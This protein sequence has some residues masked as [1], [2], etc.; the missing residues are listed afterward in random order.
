MTWKVW[1]SS[2]VGGLLNE[3]NVTMHAQLDA[4]DSAIKKGV[5]ATFKLY[6]MLL[7]RITNFLSLLTR[8]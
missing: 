5:K 8:I 2:C 7:E 6:I 4:D 3:L 1:S